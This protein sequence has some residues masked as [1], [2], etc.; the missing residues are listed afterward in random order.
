MKATLIGI[1]LDLGT[2]NLGVDVG[3]NA[4]R[5]QKI[6][7]KL[8]KVNID[9][10]DAGNIKCVNRD[11]LEAGNPKL[12][13]LNEVIRASRESALLVES[14]VK[15]REKVIALGGDHSISIGTISGA[16]N[17]LNGE[18][19]LIYLDAHGDINTDKTTLTGNIHGMP[20][21]VLLGFGNKKL[22][23]INKSSVKIAKEN[24]LHVGGIDF[25]QAEVDFINKENLCCFKISDLLSEGLS[26]LLKLIDQLQAKV[27]NIWVSFD[28]DVMDSVYAPGVGMINKAG[29]TYR[30]IATI[31][32]YIG[33]KCNV[34]GIDVVEYNPLKDVDGKTSE[35]GIE[36]I[37]KFIGSQY[38][39]Y[40]NY[41]EQNKLKLNE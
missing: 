30:E 4:F 17:A 32:E 31:A 35:L 10:T 33:Q 36:L 19:G 6:I 2:E 20:L 37:A 22:T 15:K 41:L 5:Y 28:L 21:A 3:P 34:V 14:L 16:S 24:L 40:T 23:Q 39:W 8:K 12:K 11:N 27:K 38:N 7:E 9:I 25:D 1:P 18:L 26:P 29:L 13:Y